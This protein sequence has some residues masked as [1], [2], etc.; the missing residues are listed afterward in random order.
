MLGVILRSLG[1][2]IQLNN[3]KL[4]DEQDPA[5]RNPN[6]EPY[7]SLN[8]MSVLRE[9]R[10]SPKKTTSMSCASGAE[11]DRFHRRWMLGCRCHFNDNI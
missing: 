6:L 9:M 11:N 7:P 8:T 4:F 1:C 2:T 3:L 5:K 10:D